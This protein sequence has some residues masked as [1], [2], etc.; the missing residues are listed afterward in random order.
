MTKI[1]Y[2]A[3]YGGFDFSDEAI[4]LYAQKKGLKLYAFYPDYTEKSGNKNYTMKPRTDSDKGILYSRYCKTPDWQE[5]EAWENDIERTDPVMVEVVEKLGSKRASG[6]FANIKIED[7]S[8]GTQYHITDYDGF[9][10][11]ETPD[12]YNWKTA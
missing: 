7:L 3:C 9:E 12:S 1:M 2:N 10:S 11:V 8:P 5:D 6:R 4:L